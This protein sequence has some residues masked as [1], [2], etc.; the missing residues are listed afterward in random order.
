MSDLSPMQKERINAVLRPLGYEAVKLKEQSFRNEKGKIFHPL[1]CSKL[2][3]EHSLSLESFK[4]ASAKTAGLLFAE[5]L[6]EGQISGTP[7]AYLVANFLEDDFAKDNKDDFAKDKMRSAFDTLVSK[8]Y[9]H[10]NNYRKIIKNKKNYLK[11]AVS[12]DL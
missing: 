12:L 11:K 6:E 10:A 9:D 3:G 4:N 7:I 5:K 8:I 1:E 2:E